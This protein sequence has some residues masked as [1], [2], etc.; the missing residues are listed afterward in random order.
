VIDG[1]IGQSMYGWFDEYTTNSLMTFYIG[2]IFYM[3]QM[4]MKKIDNCVS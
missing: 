2:Y 4:I 1:L 3:F